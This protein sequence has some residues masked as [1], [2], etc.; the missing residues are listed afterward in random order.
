VWIAAILSQSGGSRRILE[1]TWR[2]RLPILISRRIKEEVLTNVIRKA[3]S[4]LKEARFLLVRQKP[5]LSGRAT[6][7]VI[8][9]YSRILPN[10]DAQVF[11]EALNAEATH[12]ITLDQKHFLARRRELQRLSGM[13]IYTPGEFIQTHFIK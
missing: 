1:E 8:A 13:I 3:P 2:R 7:G 6:L 4:F 9:R 10:E 12:F 5:H 11:A